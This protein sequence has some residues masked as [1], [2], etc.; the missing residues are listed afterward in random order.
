[1]QVIREIADVTGQHR[2]S[3]AAI[4]NFDGVHLGHCEVI[5][6]A[7][8]RSLAAGRPSAV[9]T[10]EPHPRQ[11]FRPEDPP[12]R[13]MNPE[14]KAR[15]LELLGVDL[16]FE[17]EF[18]MQ[19]AGLSASE[20]SERI[21]T[22]GLGLSCAVVG[23]DFRFG[24]G[25]S[26]DAQQLAQH[27]REF[28]FESCIVPIAGS[29]EGGSWSSTSIRE[30]LTAGRPDTA[31]AILGHWHRI[32]GRVLRGRKR[33]RELGFPTANI[34][35]GGLHP[36]RFGVYAVIVD[37]LT[38]PLAGAYEGSASIGTR[39]TF[40]KNEA[41]L[42]VYI[43]DFSGD[44]YDEM[45]SVALVGFQRP[46]IAFSSVDELVAQMERD[47]GQTRELLAAND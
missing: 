1:M 36:P 47:C 10:F 34:S 11:Y 25:R 30:A 17:L 31:A 9:V 41:N 20:F 27:G 13:L 38:G 45:I 6:C 23:E 22:E 2:H 46:E 37:V 12:F 40:G 42:E 5:Q 3:V 18:G 16:L 21:L 43:L 29:N 44:I 8:N 33:G 19:L 35:L 24:R 39:P 28:G 14:A 15:R 4:G 26:G 7:L 32:E